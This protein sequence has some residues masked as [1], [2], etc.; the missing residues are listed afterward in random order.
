MLKGE[1]DLA[2]FDWWRRF[3]NLYI[4][5]IHGIRCFS[6]MLPS[7]P[8]G[9]IVN[10][11]HWLMS[12]GEYVSIVVFLILAM[13]VIDDNIVNHKRPADYDYEN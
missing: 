2:R 3:E 7:M 9:E 10:N 13:F 8:K 6:S 4:F 1:N 5:C 11:E 12:M